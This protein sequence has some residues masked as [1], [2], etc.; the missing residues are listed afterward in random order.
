MAFFQQR[1]VYDQERHRRVTGYLAHEEWWV[2]SFGGHRPNRRP[3]AWYVQQLRDAG[4]VIVDLDE[5]PSLP[6]QRAR[7]PMERRRALVRVDPDDAVVRS[8][9]GLIPFAGANGRCTKV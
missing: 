3:L 7:A 1:P 8:P 9:T 5:P 2:D 4:L 6:H